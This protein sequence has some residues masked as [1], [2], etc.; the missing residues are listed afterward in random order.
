[1]Y[2][3]RD[4]YRKDEEE[5]AID[6]QRWQFQRDLPDNPELFFPFTLSGT[7]VHILFIDYRLLFPCKD[8]GT[9]TRK[10]SAINGGAPIETGLT[11]KARD[12]WWSSKE[13]NNNS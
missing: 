10:R 3:D 2:K 5:E 12:S 9:M 11:V 6:D 13:D 4:G 1:M 7:R 8:L